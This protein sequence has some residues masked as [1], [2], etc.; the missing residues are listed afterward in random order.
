MIVALDHVALAVADP[1]SA[2]RAYQI[3][4]GVSPEPDGRHRFQLANMALQINAGGPQPSF[5]LGFAADDLA[6]TRRMLERRGL[7]A[8]GDR[9]SRA[10]THGVEMTV[11]AHRALPPPRSRAD[12]PHALDHV[13]VHTPNP[14]RAVALYGGRLGLD[15]RLD[16]ANPQWGSRLLF[17]RC[18]G[19][20]VEVSADLN[21]PV[22]DEPDRITGLAWRVADPVAAQARLA[23]AGLDVSPVRAGR[24]P[25][26]NVFTVRSGVPG[27]PALMLGGDEA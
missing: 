6:E 21:A 26:T 5:G 2:A 16:R 7:A 13:V 19:A 22:S 9:L 17:F 14:E 25:G 10:A 27:A 11:T 20:V 24:K 1:G 12:A 8:E 23:A 3:L 4:L 18:G 15:L